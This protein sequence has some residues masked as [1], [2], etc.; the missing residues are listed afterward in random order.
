MKQIT[1]LWLVLIG[2]S[3]WQTPEPNVLVYTRN[4]EGY[5]H[6]NIPYSVEALEKLGQENNFK[7]EVSD[8]PALFRQ[9]VLENYDLIIFANSNNDAFENDQQRL[10]FKRYIQAG[11]AFVGIHS[12]CGSERNWPWF[13]QMLGGKFKRHPKFQPFVLKIIDS[14]HP[15]TSFL[16]SQWEWEDECYYLDHLNPDIHVL[17]AADLTTVEDDKISDYPGKTFGNLFPLAWYHHYDGG[18]QWYTA[19]GHDPEHY[20]DPKFLKHI[21]GGIQWALQHSHVNYSGARAT[22]VKLQ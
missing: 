8:D 7:V 18:W 20:S 5:V 11:G 9:D 14:D 12:A 21:L 13:Q 10:E 17:M 15:S 16:G 19:L 2:L 22:S 4:G 1:L 6:D 3:S